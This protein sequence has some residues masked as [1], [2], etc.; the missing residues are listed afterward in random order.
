MVV[1]VNER[2]LGLPYFSPEPK[3]TLRRAAAR[4]PAQAPHVTLS[5]RDEGV[6][7]GVLGAVL[8]KKVRGI[9]RNRAGGAADRETIHRAIRPAVNELTIR[10]KVCAVPGTVELLCT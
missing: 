5:D 9:D 10:L 8:L 4:P 7:P 3:V 2:T 6:N 1:L